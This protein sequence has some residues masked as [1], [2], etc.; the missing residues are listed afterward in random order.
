MPAILL[1]I[2]VSAYA[3]FT[4]F[5]IIGWWRAIFLSNKSE[6]SS[7]LPSIII[8][9]R[10]ESNRLTPLIL[11]IKIILDKN[12]NY[13]FIFIDD[14]SDDDS[15]SLLQKEFHEFQQVKTIRLPQEL[16]GKKAAISFGI[17]HATHENIITTDADCELTE[18]AVKS[19]LQHL[20]T[21]D[22]KMAC[23]VV[24]QFSG[25]GFGGRLADL[26]FISLM[27]SGISFWGNNLP[28]MAN[29]AFL[30]FKKQAF[31]Q[32]NGFDGN[33]QFP[34]GDDVFL[35][36][37]FSSFFGNKCIRFL[38]QRND[39]IQ[40]TGDLSLNEFIER[41]IRWGAKSKAYK[42][43]GSKALTLYIFFINLAFL[44][45][46]LFFVSNGLW[47]PVIFLL[48]VKIIC[49]VCVLMPMLIRL[50]K[51]ELAPYIFPASILHPIYILF[52]GCLAVW[53]KY[54][55]KRRYYN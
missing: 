20:E 10:N 30:G 9:F 25:K 5:V 7:A 27:G 28:I 35:L 52:V 50:N 4:I 11:S 3:L 23:G 19:M 22:V 16:S 15:V 37:K 43:F 42:G 26:E 14:H 2:V 54:S 44:L 55:W 40:T 12:K 24:T 1:Y 49:D 34:G 33:E 13:E 47:Q 21:A 51:W 53:G 39:V 32:I 18:M 45:A 31:K 46:S 41:R 48:F 36:H 17:L 6:K 29:G 38:T 8:P